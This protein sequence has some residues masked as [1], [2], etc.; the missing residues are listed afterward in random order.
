[1]QTYLCRQCKCADLIQGNDCHAFL[2]LPVLEKFFANTLVLHD[3]VVQLGTRRNFQRYRLVQMLGSN[4]RQGR[5]ESLD[6]G[7]VKVGVRWCVIERKR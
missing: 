3:D 4:R 7:S 1:M 2:E 6:F 5:D